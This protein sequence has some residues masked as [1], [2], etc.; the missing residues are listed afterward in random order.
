MKNREEFNIE[1][2]EFC[3]NH[4]FYVS[5]DKNRLFCRFYGS[6]GEAAG[7]PDSLITPLERIICYLCT[8]LHEWDNT[9]E[10]EGLNDGNYRTFI[11]R[12]RK[13]SIE[14]D[15]SAISLPAELFDNICKSSMKKIYEYF[16]LEEEAMKFI[17][18]E[19]LILTLLE[20]G[21]CDFEFYNGIF[22]T[23]MK[24][25]Y[26]GGI[27][28]FL[29]DYLIADLIADHI[30]DLKEDIENFSYNPLIL[31]YRFRKEQNSSYK[32]TCR[33][34]SLEDPYQRLC[35]ANI[36]GWFSLLAHKKI[37]EARK[38][39]EYIKV[40]DKEN[41]ENLS[42]RHALRVTRHEHH[43]IKNLLSLYLEG[44]SQ[45][46]TLFK[47]YDYL[48]WMDRD[49]RDLCIKLLL[50]PHPWERLSLNDIG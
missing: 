45:G 30:T 24:E 25:D 27:T 7:L 10:K 41:K 22:F 36:M 19:E 9:V 43:T 2:A 11:D 4:N 23:L 42:S 13:N 18:S 49:K 16:L 6:I 12:I 28:S 34:L 29:E 33:E 40:N 44:I 47:K 17:S 21:N 26:R 48:T 20:K 38:K 31:L 39:L 5:P 8:T 14:K 35:K 3:K 37:K 1:I 46:F 50:K 32:E 15:V